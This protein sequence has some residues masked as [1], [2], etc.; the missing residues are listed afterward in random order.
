MYCSVILQIKKIMRSE[1]DVFQT[2][3]D[4]SYD[5]K[6]KDTNK[7]QVIRECDDAFY[8]DITKYISKDTQKMPQSQSTTFYHCLFFISRF[9]KR[10]MKNKQW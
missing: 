8:C 6:R 7:G 2:P 10:E 4:Y 9:A 3:E 1:T 5:C